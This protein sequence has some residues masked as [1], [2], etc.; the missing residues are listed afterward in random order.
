MSPERIH[1][2][3]YGFKS[4][5]WSLG[6]LLYEVS[7]TEG[8]GETRR[9]GGGRERWRYNLIRIHACEYFARVL[10]CKLQNATEHSL[11]VFPSVY[12]PP[13]FVSL[14]LTPSLTP[15]LSHILSQMAALQSPFYGESLN[16]YALVKK[17]EKC[18]YPNLPSNTFSATVCGV[19]LEE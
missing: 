14:P 10:A 15:S 13:L 17:I 12:C 4:D 5:I 19:A 9:T 6:C 16:L 3:G 8:E 18:S 1:E 2:S 11:T 7:T